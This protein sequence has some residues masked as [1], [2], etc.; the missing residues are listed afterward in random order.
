MKTM[1]RMCIA[2][3]LAAV[4]A[5][6]AQAAETR[7][8]AVTTFVDHPALDAA[9]K[10]VL[11]GLKEKGLV[12]PQ[13]KVEVQNA[14]GSPVT[15]AQIAKKFAGDRPNVIIALSTI[16]AQTLAANVKDIPIVFAAVSD[17]VAA[18]L[19]ERLDK[20]GHNLTGTCECA[21]VGPLMALMSRISPKV[22]RLGVL[23][24]AGETNSRA[25]VDR[26]KVVAK[27]R[28][29]EIVEA[30]VS[31]SA[32]VLGAAQSLVGKVDAIYVPNDN[33]VV[34]TFESVTRVALE[35][36]LP[37]YA[38]DP[39]NVERGAIAAEGT[40]YYAGGK[41]AA[42]AVSRILNGERAGD[43]PVTS[44]KASLAVNRKVAKGI[45]V[46]LPADV[47]KAASRIID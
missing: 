13:V 23:Y 37:I 21:D 18:K 42:E 5:N 24:N 25:F 47:I 3:A 39:L 8:I 19:V 14:Q 15:A 16:S 17:P 10:G 32:D 34:S 31:K 33:T 2:F 7:H 46:E 4:L 20:P 6:W 44:P 40:D 30:T 22:K 11:D 45:G 9:L 27:A 12:A 28:D 1:Y 38:S 36:K 29:V 41:G 26:I 43:I 35:A